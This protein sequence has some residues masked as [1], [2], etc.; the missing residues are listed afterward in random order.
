MLVS[1]LDTPTVQDLVRKSFIQGVKK[2]IGAIRKVFHPASQD[3]STKYKRI[4]EFDRERLAEQKLEGQSSAQRGVAEVY[5]KNLTRKTISITRKVSGEEYLGLKAHQLAENVTGVAEDIVDKIEL[6]MRNFI[7]MGTSS[8]FTDNGGFTVDTT[9]GDGLSLFNATHT[10]KNSA[11]TYS[12][13]LS[14]APSFSEDAMEEAEDYFAYNIMDNYGKRQTIK[15]N[16]LITADKATMKNRV[17]RLLKSIAPEAIEGTAN[18]NSGVK[19]TYGDK[20]QHIVVEFDVTA[21]DVTDSSKSY[22]WFLASLGGSP[23]KSFQAYYVKW[24]SP[25]V[26]PAEHDQDKWTL[27]YTARACYALGAV[28]GKGIL[29]VQAAS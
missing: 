27:S 22:Y 6:D 14:G 7:G 19:N 5:H 9:V 3:W 10:L 1:T 4:Q 24:L 25:M 23:R 28:S 16:T 26:A 15:P 13:I 21:L 11:T 2:D 17:I 18:A 12:N 29:I 20:Y 8:S